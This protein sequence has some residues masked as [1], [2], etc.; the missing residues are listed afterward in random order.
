MDNDFLEVIS[1]IYKLRDDYVLLKSIE[2]IKYEEA[3]KKYRKYIRMVCDFLDSLNL[4][5]DIDYS[6]VLSLLIDNGIF[7]VKRK[8][9]KLSINEETGETELP[10]I[11]IFSHLGMNIVL[12][13]GNCR[14]YATFHDD[15]MKRLEKDSKKFF[16]T[17]Y[18]EAGY[19]PQ[20][21]NHIANTIKHDGKLYIIDTF[22]DA[23][24]YS[25]IDNIKARQVCNEDVTMLSYKPQ[26]EIICG[27]GDIDS[28]LRQL[29]ENE[30]SVNMPSISFEEYYSQYSDL[31]D[32][33]I[34]QKEK[35]IRFYN[36]T[37]DTKKEI[38][39][40]IILELK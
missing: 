33:L 2:D 32:M 6:I 1:S 4:K 15:V 9:K 28:I 21:S 20:K 10:E 34:L 3:I 26:G 36:S 30:K 17:A 31:V 12:G 5:N 18:R 24:L 14:H 37:M 35:V 11:E 27:G 29:S 39:K 7:S 38:E 8:F 22:N 23:Y 40:G 19:E 25:F 13:E 16:C